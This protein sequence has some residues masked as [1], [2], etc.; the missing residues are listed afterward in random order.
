MKNVRPA[1]S[2]LISLRCLPRLP[3]LLWASLAISGLSACGKPSDGSTEPIASSVANAAPTKS[4]DAAKGTAGLASGVQKA[5]AAKTPVIIAIVD[6]QNITEDEIAPAVQSG[7]DRAIALD[8]AINRAVT[9]RA[10][11]QEHAAEA[12]RLLESASR[13]LLSQLYI[14]KATQRLSA[15]V[16]DKDIQE[17]YDRRVKADDYREYKAEYVLVADQQAAEEL[18]G[19]ARRGEKKAMARFKPITDQPGQWLRA[20]DFP[21]G[22]GQIASRMKAG[23]VSKP[24]A[25]RNG[26][27]VL[28]LTQVRDQPPPALESV[29][30]EIR[31]ILVSEAL[32]KDIA[33]I[34]QKSRIELK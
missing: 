17:F 23:D 28:V 20:R 33:A 6:G 1:V 27:F 26:W 12:E 9:S 31:N 11:R 25:L 22:L 29:K 14:Q 15:A 7:V 16:S 18:A 3:H 21:Y 32:V 34:R 10:V 4:A 19:D 5:G 24:I 2:T 13:E 8:R 30:T